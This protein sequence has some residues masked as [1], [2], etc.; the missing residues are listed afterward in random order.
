MVSMASPSLQT[1][2]AN[3]HADPCIQV[4][5]DI[6]NVCDTE[7]VGVSAK[8][9][10]KVF[11]DR[12]DV[13]PLVSPGHISDALFEL[14]KGT[15]SNAKV[16]S[17]KVEPQELETLLE[18]REAGFRLM[19]RESERTK[20]LLCECHGRSGFL[21]RF[22]END[23]IISVSD[24]PPAFGLD[25]LVKGIEDN[26]SEQWRDD[27]PLRGTF[28][29]DADD[30]TITNT[31]FEEG[32][33]KT[34]DATVCDPGTDS[35]YNDLV[36]N[37]IEEGGDIRVNDIAETFLSIVNC[38]SYSVV[39]FATRPEAEA[40]VRKERI[41]D[42]RQDLIDRLLTHAVDYDGDS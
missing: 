6:G 34:N 5:K 11:E 40:P 37:S 39:S 41:E 24:V 23:K 7:V 15:R 8:N 12:L 31:G 17:A 30:A 18:V 13:P 20:G 21:R 2:G 25:F 14:L 19:E 28:S 27:A 22:R 10:I 32:L 42:W 29:R 36:I 16:V 33:E 35:G 38:G 4:S 9:R 3:S 26:V 1:E